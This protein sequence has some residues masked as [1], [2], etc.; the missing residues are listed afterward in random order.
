M[1]QKWVRLSTICPICPFVNGLSWFCPKKFLPQNFSG[2]DASRGMAKNSFDQDVL[3]P[4]D[5]PLDLLNDLSK[6]EQGNLEEWSSFFAE[7]YD[8]IGT[9]INE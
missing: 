7:K 4:I 8:C 5:Q 9:L 6:E 3:T 2:R 1:Y